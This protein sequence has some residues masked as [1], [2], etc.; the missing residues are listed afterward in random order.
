MKTSSIK[1]LAIIAGTGD[2]PTFIINKCKKEDID[3]QVFLLDGEG[4]EHDYSCHNAIKLKYGEISKFIKII[5]E[6]KL[7]NLVMAGGVTKPDLRAIKVDK[8]SA[9]LVTKI[10]AKKLLGD[11]SVLNTVI[12]FFEKEGLKIIKVNDFL[13]D[14][15]AKKGTLS[16]AIP[17]K[18]DLE[19][20]EI[21]KNAIKHISKFDIGQSLVMAQK[22]IIALEAAEGTDQMIKRCKELTINYKNS[23]ILV[24]T[25][26]KSQSRK[27]DL[28]TI[29]VKTINNCHKSGIKGI[30]IQANNTL[31]LKKDDVI[32]KIDEYNMFLV[33]I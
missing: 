8:K 12:K 11:D 6:K 7:T 18:N 20:I 19:N 25:C 23:A 33:A 3:Y 31:I 21:A 16:K 22:Q 27:A 32:K 1:N 28:P 13:S 15:T 10:L 4:Y 5:K 9:S 17:G 2:L 30:A 29:G 14:I 26:K 24:K